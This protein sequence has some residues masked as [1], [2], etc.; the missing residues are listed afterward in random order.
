MTSEQTSDYSVCMSWGFREGVWDL[1]DVYRARLDYGPLK[2]KVIAMRQQFGAGKVIMEDDN[3]GKILI[4][5]FRAEKLGRLH[6]YRPKVDKETR[7]EAQ[8]AKLES[9]KYRLPEGAPFLADLKRELSAFP[10]SKYD[11]QVDALSQFLEWSGSKRALSAL[12]RDPVTGRRR[13]MAR[14]R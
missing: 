2:A 4:R 3:T 6:P 13:G 1:I 11:D 7:F 9:G 5:E 8:L 10:N 12:D 14:R